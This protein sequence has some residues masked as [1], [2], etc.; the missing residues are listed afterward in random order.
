[1]NKG[2]FGSVRRDVVASLQAVLVDQDQGDTL[3]VQG[4]ID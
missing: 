1:M 2:G 4:V 3:T